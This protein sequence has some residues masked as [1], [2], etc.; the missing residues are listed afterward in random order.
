MAHDPYRVALELGEQLSSGAPIIRNLVRSETLA[1][2]GLR[3]DQPAGGSETVTPLAEPRAVTV[4]DLLPSAT[5]AKSAV[6]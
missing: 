5:R 3:V 2:L 4:A 6:T 1:R